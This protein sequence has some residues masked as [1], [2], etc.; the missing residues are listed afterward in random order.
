[1]YIR[2]AIHTDCDDVLKLMK[3]LAEFEGYADDFCVTHAELK[4]R[5][6][7]EQDFYVLVVEKNKRIVGILVYYYLPFT[8]DLKPWIYIKELYINS[9]ARGQGFGKHLMTA[10]AQQA[11]DKGVSKIRWDV[12]SSNDHAKNFYLSLGASHNK[13][14][15]LFSLSSEN[16]LKLV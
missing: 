3:Q 6:F 11:K 15:Q 14:W 8:F 7:D 9:S 1:M 5:L 10:L 13:E 4:K 12:L 2:H 16:I